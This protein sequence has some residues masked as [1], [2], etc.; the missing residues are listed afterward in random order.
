MKISDIILDLLEERNPQKEALILVAH[1]S[2]YSD[3]GNSLYDKF[4]EV[5]EAKDKK[6]LPRQAQC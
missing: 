3:S 5:L 6:R 1:G 2:K 4:K